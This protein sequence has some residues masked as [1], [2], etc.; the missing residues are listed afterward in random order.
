VRAYVCD[1]HRKGSLAFPEFF[2]S[3]SEVQLAE[4]LERAQPNCLSSPTG[5]DAIVIGPRCGNAI[6]D[7]G[8]DCDCGT[9]EVIVVKQR[10]CLVKY[11]PQS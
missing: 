7:A 2:S 3:C 6:L 1:P 5:A 11:T 8:E 4:F 9:A 10:L